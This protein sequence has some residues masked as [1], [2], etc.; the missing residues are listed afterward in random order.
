MIKVVA[1]A[2]LPMLGACSAFPS[3]QMHLPPALASSQSEP[4]SGIDGWTHGHFEVAGHTGHY[5]RSETRLIL[6]NLFDRR[7]AH[8]RFTVIGPLTGETIEADC[9]MR[10][11]ALTFESISLTTKPMAYHCEFLSD[12]RPLPARFELQESV[13][14]LAAALARYERRGEIA[15]GGDIVKIQSVH[16]LRGSPFTTEAPIGYRFEQAGRAV[17][18]VELNGKPRLF[19][20]E[21]IEPSL[22][23]TVII[24]ALAVSLL[25]DP[26]SSNLGE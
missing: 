5:Q 9:R 25:W 24:A 3:A 21:D 14:N 13:N 15:F 18:A 12:G 11:R 8:A 19:L 16:R 4:I 22:Q 20:S 23:Q 2:V 26:A 1:L 7:S 6:F 10:E 17:A